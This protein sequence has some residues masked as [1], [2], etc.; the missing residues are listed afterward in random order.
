[1]DP[2]DA[3]GIVG[4]IIYCISLIPLIAYGFTSPS[5][6]FVLMGFGMCTLVGVAT[7][8]LV[9]RIK[10]KWI[11]KAHACPRICPGSVI[12]F[13][14]GTSKTVRIIEVPAPVAK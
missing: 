3:V 2:L 7:F 10:R 4:L 14:D 9:R 13:A 6:Y 1:M 8:E 12:H 5:I 11:K